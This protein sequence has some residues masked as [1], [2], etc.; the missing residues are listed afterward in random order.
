MCTSRREPVPGDRLPLR[1]K[2]PGAIVQHIGDNAAVCLFFPMGP[3]LFQQ[4]SVEQGRGMRLQRAFTGVFAA[5][6]CMFAA[7]TGVNAA[8]TG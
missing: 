1:S 8:F 5:V 6:C 4:A 3:L 7:V 2:A